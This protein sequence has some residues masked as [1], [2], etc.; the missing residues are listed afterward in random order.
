MMTL[1]INC[2]DYFTAFACFSSF[3]LFVQRS[4]E[5]RSFLRR[6]AKRAPCRGFVNMSA[7]ISFVPRCCIWMLNSSVLSRTAKYLMLICLVR[8]VVGLAFLIIW[9]VD[10]LSWKIVFEFR[11]ILRSL[12]RLIMLITYGIELDIH[13]SSLSVDERQTIFWLELLNKIGLSF[14]MMTSPDCPRPSCRIPWDASAN[15]L[16]LYSPFLRKVSC[17]SIVLFNYF[18]MRSS[19]ILSSE[20]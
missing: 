7:I 3:F 17:W 10:I 8:W 15:T 2:L 1:S 4:F 16:R 13:T 20:V 18:R 19:F 9:I 6:S 14:I 5:L 12:S 11:L